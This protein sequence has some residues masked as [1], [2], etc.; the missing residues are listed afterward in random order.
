[1][2]D[3]QQQVDERELLL[4]ERVARLETA[5]GAPKGI[6]PASALLQDRIA[7]LEGGLIREH[8]TLLRQLLEEIQALRREMA[9]RPTAGNPAQ[10]S[11][12]LS[13]GQGERKRTSHIY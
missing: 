10:R 11:S 13:D 4:R 2:S 1:M 12:A 6:P 9:V 5:I 3:Q 8:L 7:W